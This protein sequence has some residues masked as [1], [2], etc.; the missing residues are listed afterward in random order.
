M[1]LSHFIPYI[2][3]EF[4]LKEYMAKTAGLMIYILYKKIYYQT[5]DL[6]TKIDNV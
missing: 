5:N 1:R 6:T 4:S 3:R 2:A